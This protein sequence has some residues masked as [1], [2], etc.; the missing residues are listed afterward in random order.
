MNKTEMNKWFPDARKN[1]NIKM[2]LFCF[3]FAGGNAFTYRAWKTNLPDWINVCPA[4]LPGRGARIN[5]PVYTDMHELTAAVFENMRDFLDYP[6]AVFGY[7]MGA[8]IGFELTRL[9][10]KEGIV[11]EHLFVAASRPPQLAGRDPIIY[12]LP[13]EIFKEEISKLNGTPREILENKELLDLM[14]PLLRGDFQLVETYQFTEGAKLECPI[15][16]FGG[17]DDEEVSEDELKQWRAQTDSSFDRTIFEGNHF[18]IHHRQP[19]ILSYLKKVL[20]VA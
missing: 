10:Q 6:F 20:A 2:R 8:I 13:N 5:E 3:P 16:A 14:L 1:E 15:S 9:L 4:H 12:D 19:E 18:F 17:N 7:S 11:P